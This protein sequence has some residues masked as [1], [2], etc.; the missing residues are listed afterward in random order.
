[1]TFQAQQDIARSRS[2]FFHEAEVLFSI[3]D[4]DLRCVDANEFT[5]KVLK[6]PR[7]EVVGKHM[8]ELSPY[9]ESTGRLQQYQEVLRTGQTLV[10]DEMQTHLGP[11]FTHF[12]VKAFRMEKGL[13]IISKNIT[14]LKVIIAEDVRILQQQKELLLNQNTQLTDFC[15]IV[16]HNL[17][18]PLVNIAMLADYMEMATEH[19]DLRELAGRLKPVVGHLNETFEHLVETLQI[20]SDLSVQSE[21][22]DL[23]S[24]VD[25]IL[26]GYRAQPAFGD[27]VVT[28]DFKVPSVIFPKKYLQSIVSNL[29]SN[30][31][32]YRS[33]ERP[34]RLHL[35]S[36]ME[37]GEVRMSVSDNGLGLDLDLHRNRIFKIRQVF[38]KHPDAKGF[39]LYMTRA[40]VEMMGGTIWVESQPDAGSTFYIQFK[41][42]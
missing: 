26:Q 7:E 38:H 31:F 9:V 42:S 15:H 5:L 39:G 29:V 2:E 4:L 40:Q 27:C 16:S 33:P 1:M 41:Q 17:R 19:D 11:G 3:W 22:L 23:Q 37:D 24:I 32:K 14:D 36:Q 28:T 8:T 34:L 20:K 10:I 21:P 30:A 13:G 18:A 6:L 35:A 25:P 12:R